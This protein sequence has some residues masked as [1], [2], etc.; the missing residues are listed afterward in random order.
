MVEGEWV[1]QACVARDN[2]FDQIVDAA[3]QGGFAG[4][5]AEMVAQMVTALVDGYLFQVREEG[6]ADDQAR[7]LELIEMA[8]RNLQ[9]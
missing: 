3:R 9:T 1:L 2:A 5:K 4:D 6:E 7:G 8:T